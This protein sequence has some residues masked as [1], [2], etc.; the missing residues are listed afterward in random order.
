MLGLQDMV[1]EGV[2]GT[3]DMVPEGVLGMQELVLEQWVVSV[4]CRHWCS[5]TTWVSKS[6]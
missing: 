6:S 1:P 4:A 2:L 5:T 3:Q